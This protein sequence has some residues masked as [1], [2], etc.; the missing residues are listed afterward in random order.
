VARIDDQVES[1]RNV[2]QLERLSLLPLE[3]RTIYWLWRFKREAGANGME[4]FVLEPP[5]VYSAQVWTAL[6]EVGAAE[7]VRRLEAAVALARDG[8][9]EFSRL[10]DQ[11]WFTQFE[12]RAEFPTLQSV[13]QG[14]FPLVRSLT[15]IMAGYIRAHAQVFFTD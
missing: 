6:R 15:G 12:P 1:P 2:L 11:S 4:V 9:A 5:G 7:L 14:I 3:V 13:D 10:K 8:P